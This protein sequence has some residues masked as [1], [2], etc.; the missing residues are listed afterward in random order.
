MLHIIYG[1]D[2]EKGRAKFRALLTQQSHALGAEV[3]HVLEGEMSDGFLDTLAA[4]QGLFGDTTLFVFDC[5]FDK[6]AEQEM[7]LAHVESL[8]ESP[9]FFLVFEPLLEKSVAGGLKDANVEV[10]EC[11]A[12]KAGYNPDF[13]IFSL[14]D[15]LGARNKKELWVLYQE[16]LDNGLSAEEISGTLFWA[17]KNIALM[18]NAKPGDDCGMSPYVAKK[19]RGFATKYSDEE[20]V[21]LSRSL[22]TM[23]HEAHRGGEPMEV[24]LERFILEL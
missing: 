12:K 18:K 15:A 13:N 14:G 3:R 23:Y 8:K 17:V 10:E 22:T 6:K 20:I 5:V 19:A 24:A 7:L 11:V 16:A 1:N 4:S 9:N 21:N 2:R